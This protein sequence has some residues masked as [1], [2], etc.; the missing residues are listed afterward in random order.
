MKIAGIIAEYNPFHLGH[1]YQIQYAKKILGADAVVV[2]MSGDFVQRGAPSMLEKHV[3]AQMALEGGADLILELPVQFATAS[4]ERFATGGTALLQGLGIIDLL[5]FGCESGDTPDF[6]TAARLLSREPLGYRQLLKEYLAKGMSFP[7]ARAKAFENYL[8][9]KR[10]GCDTDC[11]NDPDLSRLSSLLS[12]PNNILGIEYC[13]A[14]L[15]LSSRMQPEAIRRT[16]G[17]YHDTRLLP[18]TLPS[19]SG[20]RKVVRDY[21]S[22]EKKGSSSASEPPALYNWMPESASRLL[23]VSLNRHEVV[24]EEHL[25]ALVFYALKRADSMDTLFQFQDMTR[26]LSNRIHHTLGQ[27]QGFSQYADLLKTREITRSHIQRALLHVFLGLIPSPALP[28][29]ARI[30]G[31]RRQS[32]WILSEIQ[33]HTQLPLI[34]KAADAQKHLTEDSLKDFQQNIACCGLY[35]ILRYSAGKEN[36]MDL[37]FPHEYQKQIVIL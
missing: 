28:S 4:A 18:G 11:K 17:S 9:C 30:L 2:V 8:K 29:Y 5:C 35:D 24:T 6:L 14:L 16:G 25:D 33:S 32:A 36:R 12:A 27:Y 31:F 20:I 10:S 22:E 1:A 34:S 7:A 15:R 19:A 23:Q 3:R 26:E 37:S 21:L 13:K